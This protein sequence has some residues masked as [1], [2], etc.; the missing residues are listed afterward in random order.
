[1]WGCSGDSNVARAFEDWLAPR[2]DPASWEDLIT[3]ASG[4]LARENRTRYER[5][6]AVGGPPEVAETLLAGIIAGRAQ[7]VFWNRSGN[8]AASDE[9]GT[10]YFCG[11]GARVAKIALFTMAHLQG[12]AITES[13]TEDEFRNAMHIGT[14]YGPGCAFP[15]RYLQV[16]ADG[17]T[18][19]G[20]DS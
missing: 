17:V 16:S 9:A 6:M 11:M 20:L 19:A 18:D 14:R 8:G 10:P 15:V 12:K 4:V 7:V 5:S 3:Q 1:M 13:P 2:R